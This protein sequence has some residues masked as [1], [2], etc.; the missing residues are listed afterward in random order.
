[1]RE[2]WPGELVRQ[3]LDELTK[4]L[5]PSHLQK[6]V[7]DLLKIGVVNVSSQYLRDFADRV[8]RK[9]HLPPTTLSYENRAGQI[10][11]YARYSGARS[12]TLLK[13]SPGRVSIT[14]CSAIFK[15]AAP[16]NS[17]GAGGWGEQTHVASGSWSNKMSIPPR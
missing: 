1:V 17:G 15:R 11:R 4:A 2:S 9:R 6:L 8:F 13:L 3:P 7:D 16:R 10:E 14:G 5:V 12:A